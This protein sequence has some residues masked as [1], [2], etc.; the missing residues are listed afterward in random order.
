[1]FLA[2]VDPVVQEFERRFDRLARTAFGDAYGSAMPMDCVRR[3]DDV[4][5]RFDVPGV[6]PGSIDVTVDGDVLS[7]AA[8][9]EEEW[10][11]DDH[12]FVRERPMG[13][14]TRRIH[15]SENLDSDRIEADYSGGVLTVRIPL[16]ERAK[17]RKIAIGR[18]KL[19]ALKA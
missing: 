5:L 12:P 1:M 17:P 6:D 13:T 3:T 8:T 11:H 16:R 4:L 2:T 18:G 15:L 10:G 19:K 7:V 9:R 14:V